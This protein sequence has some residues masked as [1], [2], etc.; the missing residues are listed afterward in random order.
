MTSSLIDRLNAV[1][2]QVALKRPVRVASTANLALSGFQTIDGVTP[3]APD[4]NLRVLVK[5]QAAP[6]ENGIYL[7]ATGAWQRTD[8]FDGNR[9]VVKGTRVPVTEGS[10]GANKTYVVTSGDPI[11]IDTTGITFSE[12]TE[13]LVTS[14]FAKPRATAR[15]AAGSAISLTVTD[16]GTLINVDCSGADKVVT[17]PLGAT[18]ANGDQIG[19]RYAIG[20]NQI[21]IACQG[22][23]AI[24]GKTSFALGARYECLWLE[25]DG[26]AYNVVGHAQPFSTGNIVFI[27]VVSRTLTT[28]PVSPEPGARY[29]I[30]ANGTPNGDWGSYA[31]ND[32]VES[33]GQGGWIRYT[34]SESWHAF[35]EAE[36]KLVFYTGAAWQ[37]LPNTDDPGASVL[38]YALFQDQRANGVEG[39]T[40][41]SAIWTAR[42]L[43]TTIANTI[44]GCSLAADTVTLPAGKYLVI[45]DAAFYI[46]GE[47]HLRF[48]STTTATALYGPQTRNQGVNQGDVLHIVGVLNLSAQE[49]FRLEYWAELTA[50]SSALGRSMVG[51]ATEYY[52][53]VQILDL[54]S[55]V[56]PKGDQGEQGP[57][58]FAGFKYIYDGVSTAVPGN[59][60]SGKIRFNGLT[61]AAISAASIHRLSAETDAPDISDE[62]ARWGDAG[63]L[64]M[65]KVGAEQHWVTFDVTN[66][67]DNGEYLDLTLVYR[68][69]A[70]SFSDTNSVSL[71]FAPKGETGAS[72]SSVLALDYQWNTAT[73]DTD[74]G[75]GKLL[76]TGGNKINISDLDRLTGDVS[77]LI[78]AFDELGA[79]TARGHL[80][81]IDHA[82]PA[83]RSVY[84]VTGSVADGGAYQSL[85]VT[86]VQSGG[87]FSNNTRVALLFVP[88]GATG[89]IGGNTGAF[90][91]RLLRSDNGG[92]TT[93]QNSNIAV[94]DSGH[95]SG[96]GN[97]TRSGFDTFS[98]QAAP[99]APA[100]NLVVLYPK[101][102][103]RFYEKDDSGAERGLSAIGRHTV[104][105]PAAAMIARSTNGAA[106]GTVEMPSNR[107]MFKTLDFDTTTPEFAQ[108]EIHFPKSWNLATVAFQPVWSHAATSANFG[109]VWSLAGV[110]R[111]DDDPGDVAFGTAQTSADTGG[112]TNDI[113]IGPESSAIAI[114]GA[115]ATGDTVQFQI[116][117]AVSDAGDTMAIDA[118]LH[119]VRLFYTT[120]A[121]TD[122]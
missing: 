94:D 49:A 101:S 1:S 10:V 2:E 3:A 15:T 35:V 34:P 83:N 109:V 7:M 30:A 37:G 118:R 54:A 108:F 47:T 65:A 19:I 57:Q 55:L 58:G 42:T 87:V 56:G 28:P 71:Q 41:V 75:S 4:M 113:Y 51:N 18:L 70:G 74:P 95:M 77:A 23:D 31:N 59:P 78:G 48:K 120:N 121:A 81:I 64:K 53:S 100:S 29:I 20:A 46:T 82:A 119:G 111:S 44:T 84:L 98:E 16:A 79:P 52:A 22:S 106:P 24:N 63:I 38:R 104:W 36:N 86:L 69:S 80:Y 61:L 117:R 33:N 67:V 114:D 110:A 32:V 21:T 116:S 27:K 76:M 43:Q 92:G 112:T 40:A 13:S 8:D 60:G 102:D 89:V 103:G 17:L 9:D 12:I 5:N 62:I 93:V 66:V 90:D 88:A 68:D 26:S 96:I 115:P 6:S 99:S 73:S 85:T 107:N 122:A 14:E 72:G 105:I 50:G 39:G 25:W 97:L 11:V 91:N 45:A